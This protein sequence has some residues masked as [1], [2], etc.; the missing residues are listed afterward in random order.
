MNMEYGWRYK[1][2]YS[3]AGRNFF[4][5]NIQKTQQQ[6]SVRETGVK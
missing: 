3:F 2:D 1:I 4:K 5:Y 6:G